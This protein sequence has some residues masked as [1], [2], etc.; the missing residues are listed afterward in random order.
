MHRG[1]TMPLTGVKLASNHMAEASEKVSGWIKWANLSRTFAVVAAILVPL[2]A[3]FDYR[4]LS[5][6]LQP[7]RHVEITG[8]KFS[9]SLCL[10]NCGGQRNLSI[11]PGNAQ[12]FTAN[13]TGFTALCGVD[14]PY[15]HRQTY[16]ARNIRLIE[17]WP[18][19]GVIQSM[20]V[21]ADGMPTHVENP[22]A[23]AYAMQFREKLQRRMVNALLFT[24][25]LLAYALLAQLAVKRDRK[26]QSATPPGAGPAE[27]C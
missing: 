5:T 16:T 11:Y 7:A 18:G 27:K 26:Q 17:M 1:R 10:R 8:A 20:D 6:L 3:W 2:F 12:K 4:E 13:C 15:S 23:E 14:A 19:R 22:T 9:P 24:A 25:G 21:V